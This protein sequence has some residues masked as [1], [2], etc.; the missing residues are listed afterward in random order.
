MRVDGF[1]I[2]DKPEGITSLDVVREVKR[3][4]GIRKAGH[5]GTL[6]PFATGVLPIALNEGTKLIPFLDE[7]PKRYEGTLTLGEE[8][9]TDDCTGKIISRSPWGEATRGALEPAFQSFCGTIQQVPPMFSAVKV[10]GRRLYHLARKG[11]EIER[12][13]RE[14]HIFEIRIEAIDLPRVQFAVSCSKGTYVR[15]LARDI[16]RKI[17][18]GAHLLQL[19]RVQSGLFSI[20]KAMVWEEL[21]ALTL[22]PDSLP[23]WLIP[24]GDAL[25][26]FPEVIGDERLVQKV[27][28]GQGVLV[29]DLSPQSLSGFER[30]EWVK[31]ISPGEGLVAIVRP[32]INRSDISWADSDSVVF[33]PLRVFHPP[34]RESLGFPGGSRKASR[35]D[36]TPD[37]LADAAAKA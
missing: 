23:S 15:T 18:C 10:D 29:R 27:R 8:T 31:I 36:G 20:A 1:L 33:R 25:A 32:E 28:F 34:S 22:K 9:A 13:A 5:I 24:L 14:V 4:L 2:V 6:D 19:R 11:I 12:K 16:G 3:R 30:G 26:G 37:T 35:R 7:E 21:K 17:G